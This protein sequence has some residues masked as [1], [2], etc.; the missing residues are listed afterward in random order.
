MKKEPFEQLG[1]AAPYGRCN[2]FRVK[3]LYR[4]SYKSHSH[5]IT[6][7]RNQSFVRPFRCLDCFMK[8]QSKIQDE[9][10]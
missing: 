7:S 3:C 8:E 6:E 5:G 2:V 4:K 9:C 1:C 10:E